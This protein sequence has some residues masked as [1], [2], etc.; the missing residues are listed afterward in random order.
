MKRPSD[1]SGRVVAITGGARGIGLATARA[2]HDAGARVALGDVDEDAVAAASDALG[3]EVVGVR[4]DVAEEASFEAFLARVER[5]L[6]PLYT[7]VNNAGIMPI[8]P[9]LDEPEDTARRVMEVNVLG[10]ITGTRLALRRMIPRGRGQ[11][12]N[13]ASAAGRSPVPG[14]ASYCASK[15]A[16]LAYTDTAR[17][18]H[19][20]SEIA[21][22]CV[23]PSF[24]ETELISGTKGIRFIPTVQ[25]DDVGAAIAAA[26]ARSRNADVFIPRSVGP[27]LWVQALTGRRF[28]DLVN[29]ALGAD[30]TFLEVDRAARAAYDARIMAGGSAVAPGDAGDAE[31]RSRSSAG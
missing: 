29:R 5:D 23:L 24:T 19:A 14:G 13:V 20:G 6:G 4:L 16:I 11:V 18:E 28:R 7:L 10:C 9:L 26:V 21:F 27:T 25:P 3:P 15:A 31:S 22:T 2:L 30:R 1:V 12:V 8:G 17:V